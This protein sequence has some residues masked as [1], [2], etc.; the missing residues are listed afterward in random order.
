MF[1]SSIK[2]LHLIGFVST[3]FFMS[4][5][6][7]MLQNQQQTEDP[8]TIA[9]SKLGT[10]IESFK[11]PDG[12]YEL[13]IQQQN[14]STQKQA[15]KFLV[16]QINTNKVVMEKKFMPGYVRWVGDSSLEVLD[17]PGI[18]RANE[19]LTNYKKIIDV[20]QFKH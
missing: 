17:I 20:A 4:G 16:I 6:K 10:S 11:S 2:F 1:I 7:P 18:V 8:K 13:F 15:I 14:D 12:R 5:C 3:A 19:D 9:I